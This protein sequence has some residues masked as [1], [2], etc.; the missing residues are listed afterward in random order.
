M[1]ARDRP[2]SQA[3]L[4]RLRRVRGELRHRTPPPGIL[5]HPPD[6]RDNTAHAV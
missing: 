3:S 6:Q 2:V 5:D 1:M 4:L